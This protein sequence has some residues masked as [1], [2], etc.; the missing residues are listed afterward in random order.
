M[1]GKITREFI[2][3]LKNEVTN[4]NEF[5]VVDARIGLGFT[6]IV[7]NDGNMGICYTFSKDFK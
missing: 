6:S 2:A 1:P 7:L 3:C 4:L 5:K